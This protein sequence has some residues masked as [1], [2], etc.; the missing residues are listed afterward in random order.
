MGCLQHCTCDLQTEVNAVLGDERRL[1][2]RHIFLWVDRADGASWDASATVDAL[3][4]VNVELV[5]AF[6]DA[7]DGANLDAGGIFGADAGLSD[8]VCHV[9][10]SLGKP[11]SS[12]GY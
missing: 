8:D 12:R 9:G 7:L 4:R 10:S 5:V 2:A 1:I 3:I 6:V 11:S